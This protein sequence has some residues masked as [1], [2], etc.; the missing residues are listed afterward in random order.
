[1]TKTE[2]QYLRS[3]AALRMTGL[4]NP[5]DHLA[6]ALPRSTAESPQEFLSRA[7]GLIVR[8]D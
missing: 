8:I 5:W 6:Q 2:A 3:F 1:M 4:G 7:R